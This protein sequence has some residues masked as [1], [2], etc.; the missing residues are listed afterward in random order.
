M[1]Y[2]IICIISL[3]ILWY[4]ILEEWVQRFPDF[5]PLVF[6]HC[7][8]RQPGSRWRFSFPCGNS[9]FRILPCVTQKSLQ[10]YIKGHLGSLPRDRP[11]VALTLHAIYSVISVWWACFQFWPEGCISYSRSESRNL[12]LT[13]SHNS[14]WTPLLSVILSDPLFF[15]L[16]FRVL[17][18][19]WAILLNPSQSEYPSLLKGYNNWT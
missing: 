1:H 2:R 9:F 6:M 14:Q 10:S 4:K 7:L 13:S 11:L 8:T 15:I 17:S 12:N 5:A 3:D 19:L 16:G 18:L